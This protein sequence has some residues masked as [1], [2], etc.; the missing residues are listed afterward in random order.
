MN[1]KKTLRITG[2]I[3]LVVM[4]AF[5]PVPMTFKYKDKLPQYT[6]EQIDEKEEK[7]DLTIKKDAFS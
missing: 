1:V 7:E 5:F 3:I 4:A 6:T 2:L